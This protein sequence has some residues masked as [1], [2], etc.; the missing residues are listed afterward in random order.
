MSMN[1]LNQ[2]AEK[3]FKRKSNY[4]FKE[5]GYFK[6]QASIGRFNG[7]KLLIVLSIIELYTHNITFSDICYFLATEIVVC[8]MFFVTSFCQVKNL[9]I[10]VC[11]ISSVKTLPLSL[12]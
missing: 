12:K 2:S 5:E 7:F 8:N 1:N 6:E 4:V 9:S 10:G 11:F 3:W